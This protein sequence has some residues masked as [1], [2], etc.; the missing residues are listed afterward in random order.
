MNLVLYSTYFYELLMVFTS[1]LA[2]LLPVFL[3]LGLIIFRKPGFRRAIIVYLESKT[4]FLVL[5][6]LSFFK[7]TTKG[8]FLCIGPGYL[9][10]SIGMSEQCFLVSAFFTYLVLSTLLSMN[11]YIT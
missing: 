9:K 10:E 2:A 5:N 11:N 7:T 1:V 8:F 4:I 6:D 3:F